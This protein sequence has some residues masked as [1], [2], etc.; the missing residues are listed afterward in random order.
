M[1]FAGG[2]YGLGFE[3]EFGPLAC[4]RGGVGEVWGVAGMREAVRGSLRPGTLVSGG[5]GGSRVLN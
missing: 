5:E 2:I 3:A 1:R 4:D